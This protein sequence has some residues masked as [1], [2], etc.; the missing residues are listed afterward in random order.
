MNGDDD[1]IRSF[2]LAQVA[3]FVERAAACAGVR[4]IALVGSLV[5]EKLH[6]KDA[7][8]LVT[9]D[10][11]IDLAYLAKAARG[12]KGRTQA[13]NKSS[14]IFICDA[15]TGRY[16]G[17]ICHYSNCRPFVR[18]SCRADRCGRRQYLCDDLRNLRLPKDVVVAPPL[19]LWPV[20]VRRGVI[21][22]DVEEMVSRLGEF[23][24]RTV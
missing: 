5:T 2:L 18:M 12:M 10:A 8:V 9:V 22:R 20:V 14:D 3:W 21:P 19:E 6:P 13:R 17:R 23:G 15:T 24:A 7:D 1:S 4:R 11:D 16:V